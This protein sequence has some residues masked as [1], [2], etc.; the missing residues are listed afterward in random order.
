MRTLLLIPIV[1][2]LIVLAGVAIAQAVGAAVSQGDIWVAS[3]GTLLASLAGAVPLWL[4]RGSEQAVV[5]QAA[6]IAIT[7]HLFISAGTAA[8]VYMMKIVNTSP[9]FAYWLM[10]MYW[11]TLAIVATAAVRLV[12]E[13]SQGTLK[14]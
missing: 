3:V 13:A 5:A 11:G 4:S 9:A 7:V 8:A 10:A 14:T 12:R 1:M 2:L 6:L